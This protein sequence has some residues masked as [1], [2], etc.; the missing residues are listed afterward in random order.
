MNGNASSTFFDEAVFL[1]VCENR[2]TV[3]TGKGTPMDLKV[4]QN[5]LVG[6][7]LSVKEVENWI[8][9]ST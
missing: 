7:E 8:K 4:I 9:G 2:F 6:Y 5:T 3:Y 1:A